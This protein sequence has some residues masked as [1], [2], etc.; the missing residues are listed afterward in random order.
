[1]AK[2]IKE[3][4]TLILIISYIT[5]IN[6]FSYGY[7]SYPVFKKTHTLR[8]ASVSRS[9]NKAITR[10]LAQ[11]EAVGGISNSKT[12]S[13][14]K[15]MAKYIGKG[16]V[17]TAAL[18]LFATGGIFYKNWLNEQSKVKE[19]F[20]LEKVLPAEQ[21]QIILDALRDFY[22]LIEDMPAPRPNDITTRQNV[23]K[24]ARIILNDILKN[25]NMIYRYADK[26]HV[27]PQLVAA[28]IMTEKID[29]R[30]P[31]TDEIAP[32]FGYDASRGPGQITERALKKYCKDTKWPAYN[33]KSTEEL[34]FD[35]IHE[36]LMGEGKNIQSHIRAVVIIL[37]KIGVEVQD[38]TGYP[39]T[40]E[41]KMLQTALRYTSTFEDILPAPASG[42]FTIQQLKD[43]EKA[44]SRLHAYMVLICKG[45]IEEWTSLTDRQ[46]INKPFVI[47]SQDQGKLFVL[48]PAGKGENVIYSKAS[49]AGYAPDIVK[50][51]ECEILLPGSMR[52][53]QALIGVCIAVAVFNRRTKESFLAHLFPVVPVDIDT[54]DIEAWKR[55]YINDV[56]KD[57]PPAECNVVVVGSQ[58]SLNRYSAIR[59]V[60]PLIT[61]SDVIAILQTNGATAI[62]IDP[63]FTQKIVRLNSKG[64]LFIRLTG[65]KFNFTDEGHKIDISKEQKEFKQDF[66]VTRVL[67]NIH[68]KDVTGNNAVLNWLDDSKM[69]ELQYIVE[70]LDSQ[71]VLLA[72]DIKTEIIDILADFII[73]KAYLGKPCI[74]P[75]ALPMRDISERIETPGKPVDKRS[76]TTAK[77]GSLIRVK[78]VNDELATAA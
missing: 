51:G 71:D 30:N 58:S 14:G 57:I 21:W 26:Y 76:A 9:D 68:S 67:E 70:H 59:E 2:I 41:Q 74:R 34:E 13:S 19:A 23:G 63:P 50:Q 33:N 40:Q 35:E 25:M 8:P 61:I 24:I 10:A 27:S 42:M 54:E 77:T 38:N 64:E 29:L 1:M 17:I 72:D 5:T 16:I 56:L 20:V 6:G 69:Q 4:I 12:S 73:H 48:P 32:Y 60:S 52:S 62:H 65:D 43:S 55:N 39:F 3:Y 45:L 28:V 22:A 18:S 49:S 53:L 15:R 11:E 66:T 78:I 44:R 37:S 31:V 36:I 75:I 47:P 46:E 7:N